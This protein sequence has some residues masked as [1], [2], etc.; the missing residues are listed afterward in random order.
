M[1]VQEEIL[2]AHAERTLK[3]KMTTVTSLMSTVIF[4]ESLD[5]LKDTDFYDG[6][7]KAAGKQFEIQITN[8][9]NGMVNDLWDFNE[10]ASSD[11]TSS[12]RDIASY[13]ATL[14]PSEIVTLASA[15]EKG[16]IEFK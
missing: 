12:I 2:K 15:M 16:Q 13:V 4:N 8:K 9:C 3:A 14:K 10:I 6:K 5:D 1:E 11:L 7:L